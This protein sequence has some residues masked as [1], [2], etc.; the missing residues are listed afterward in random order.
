[1]MMM[2]M[3]M[4]MCHNWMLNSFNTLPTISLFFVLNIF[5]DSFLLFV[6]LLKGFVVSS[7][8]ANENCMDEILHLF[9]VLLF[10]LYG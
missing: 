8:D 7:T 9:V 10:F 5:L 4:A 6:A 2:M 1:M 3:M